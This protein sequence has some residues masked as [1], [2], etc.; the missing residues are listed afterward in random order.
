MW[1]LKFIINR[2][3]SADFSRDTIYLKPKQDKVMNILIWY[4][5]SVGVIG[6]IQI[7]DMIKILGHGN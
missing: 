6:R 7:N 4:E 2:I 1:V 3:I 5:F